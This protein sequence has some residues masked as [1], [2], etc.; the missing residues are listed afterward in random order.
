MKTPSPV[1]EALARR[2][3]RSQ[4]GR[5]GAANRDLLVLLE[6]LLAEA[7]CNEGENRALAE[8]QLAEAESVGL[9]VRV[10]VHKRD[11][12]HI[13]QIRFP[14]ANE[15]A[16]Y[17]KISRLSPTKTRTNL[18]GQFAVAAATDIPTRWREK[19]AAWCER[20]RN[21]ALA[22][23][24]IAGFDR[25]PSRANGELLAL[26]PKLLA[27]DG[28]SLIRFA[29]CVL[30]GS[31]KQLEE[32]TTLERDGEF[33]GQLRGKL[34]RLL[35]DIT[36]GEIRTLDD[37]GIIS[38]PRSVL[39]HGPLKLCLDGAWLDFGI[40][41]GSFRL[42]QTDIER[43]ELIE[44]SSL[45]CTTIENETTFHELA[46]LQSGELLICTSYPGS[47]TVALLRRLPP[48]IDCWHFGDSDEA[49]FEILRVLRD[50]SGCDFRPLHMQVGRIPFEQES[51]GRPTHKTWPFYRQ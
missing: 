29:S 47:G 46:K 27:W 10:P 42:S 39:V 23:R 17:A 43:A 6:E 51:L 24:S 4:A 15:D 49:G 9:L 5:T 7:G 20:M 35:E 28:E 48:K 34:G 2:Y 19:W 22:G 3:E 14:A 38:N 37:I 41:H 31:S 21:E 40:L 36:G 25:E 32:L 30:C 44:T 26:L 13:H 50:K 11:P 12:S 18:A 16:L 8:Q 1:L 33:S 45:R